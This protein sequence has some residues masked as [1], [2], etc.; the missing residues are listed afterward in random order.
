MGLLGSFFFSSGFAVNSIVKSNRV[1]A[2]FE[3][4]Q[5]TATY[6]FSNYEPP[7]PRWC[8][9]PVGIDHF[10]LMELYFLA[11]FNYNFY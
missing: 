1:G 8:F 4:R 9:F 7:V 6:C 3:Q 2:N 11:R 10:D 5:T